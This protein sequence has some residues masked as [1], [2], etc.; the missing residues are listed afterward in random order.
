MQG[1][2]NFSGRRFLPVIRQTEAAECGLACLAMVASYHGYRTDMNSLR[3]RYPVSLKGVTLRDLM[4]I[5]AHLGLA[6]RPL[7]IELGHLSQLRLPAIL[8][9]DMVRFVVLKAYKKKA[10]VGPD[11][12]AGEKWFPITEASRHFTGVVLELSPTEEFC[13]TDERVRLPFSVFWSGMSG[14]THVLTQILVLSVVIEILILAAPFYM[15]LTV[16]EVIA[17]GDVDLLLVLGLGFALLV[18]IKVASTPTRSFI[19][20]ILQNTLS[21]QIGAR[22]FH[23]LVRLPLSF[24]EKRHI[25]DILSR[26]GSIEPIRNMLAEG[27]ITGLID[28]LM[29]VLMLAL[30]FAYSVQ[31]GF[32]VLFAFA[33]YAALRLALFRMFRQRSETAIQSRAQENSNFIETVRAVQ[34]LKMLNRESERERQAQNRYADYVNANVRLGPGRVSFAAANRTVSR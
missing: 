2:L 24:F 17:R 12:A 29:S 1:L 32:V 30:M 27:L 5:A 28:G 33:L 11:P 26:F 13:R 4:E 15:Q 3:R 20:L 18:L 16:D 8:H 25:G 14:N 10:C 22:L 19:V 9:W 6:C 7:R 31:L 21:F 23:H 34:S